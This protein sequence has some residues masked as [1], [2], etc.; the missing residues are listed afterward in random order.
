MMR[1]FRAGLAAFAL[2]AAATGAGAQAKPLRVLFIGNSYTYFNNLPATIADFARA[3]HEA[4]P[5]EATVVLVGG[6]TLEA[7]LAQGDAAREIARGGWDAIV[8]QDQSLR[9]IGAPA[10]LWHDAESFA[11]LAKRVGARILFYETW[12]REATPAQQ[13]ALSSAYHQAA[14]RTDGTVVHVGDAWAAFR[15][16]E[17]AGARSALFFIDGSHPSTAGTYLAACV[18]Y[19]ALYSHAPVGLPNTVRRTQEQPP[20]GPAPDSPRDSIAS[21]LAALLQRAAAGR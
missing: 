10:A 17:P 11:A 21:N 12:A 7:H 15:R 4:R 20:V 18:F 5:L 1:P 14:S 6:A 3:R 19:A 8:L 2:L 16:S 9:P 13:E